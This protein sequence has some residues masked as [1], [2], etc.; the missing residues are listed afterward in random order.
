MEQVLDRVGRREWILLE[1][2]DEALDRLVDVFPVA[3]GQAAGA[4]RVPHVQGD[5]PGG[6]A[7]RAR[8]VEELS[9]GEAH[10]VRAGRER[11]GQLALLRM[12]GSQAD[13]Q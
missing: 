6:V 5:R 11:R 1:A 9:R 10:R 7:I 2:D 12:S 13:Q 4:R 8:G 3:Q